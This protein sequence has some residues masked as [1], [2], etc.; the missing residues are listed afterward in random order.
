MEEDLDNLRKRNLK[1]KIESL[2]IVT[3]NN[4]RSKLEQE[5]YKSR[6]D[7]VGKVINWEVCKRLKFDHTA[8]W[9]MPKSVSLSENETHRNIWDFEIQSDYLIPAR[10]PDLVIIND[11]HCRV[12]FAVPV[13]HKVKIKEN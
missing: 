9:Y 5:D 12:D 10:R 13:D 1:K 11:Y 4:E 6:H 7:W 8:K 3:E 2:L